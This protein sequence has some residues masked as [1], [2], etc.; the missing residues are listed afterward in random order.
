MKFTHCPLCS[1]AL[2]PKAKAVISPWLRNLGI[3]RKRVSKYLNCEFCDSG[4]FDYRYSNKEMGK[5][6][7]DYRGLKYLDTRIKWEPW[8]SQA[9]NEEHD[10]RK[11]ILMRQS[12]L[13]E[14][15]CKFP[16]R[17]PNMVVDIGGD[18]GQYIPNLG[19]R[20]SYVIESSNKDLVDGVKR[21]SSIND[22]EKC[23]L[24]FF[25]HVLEHVANP[26]SEIEELLLH[27]EYVYIE[28]PFG[29]PEITKRRK[30]KIWLFLKLIASI[31]PWLWRQSSEPATGRKS[32]NSTLVQSEHINF[33][34][35]K[36]LQTLAEL[37]KVGARIEV[38][39]IQTPDRSKAHVIQ[40]LF[41]PQNVAY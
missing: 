36:S 1:Q 27:A 34:S 28:V 3:K 11:F 16:I 24:I 5:I 21:L 29:L 31:S 38:N 13:T 19:Q 18:R 17:R 8:Y 12:A 35:E 22:L 41:G 6:Y 25:S 9:F 37:L 20:E 40:C 23:D 33:F 26:R 7:N 39:S 30:S 2:E 32:Q 10:S 14:F 15:L 4:F